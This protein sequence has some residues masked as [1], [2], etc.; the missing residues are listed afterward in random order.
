MIVLIGAVQDAPWSSEMEA[1]FTNEDAW[2]RKNITSF[3]SMAT[4][5]LGSSGLPSPAGN[6]ASIQPV[7]AAGSSVN[8]GFTRRPGRKCAAPTV[9]PSGSRSGSCSRIPGNGLPSAI[10]SGCG[11]LQAP[12]SC[13]VVYHALPPFDRSGAQM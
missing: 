10:R 1:S 7:R 2:S 6:A 13:V 12:P 3:P 4:Y 9:R 5:W 11:A 8:T